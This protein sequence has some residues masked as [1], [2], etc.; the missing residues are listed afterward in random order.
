MIKKEEFE[1]MKIQD[2]VL[3][4]HNLLY[5]FNKPIKTKKTTPTQQE[6]IDHCKSKKSTI[7]PYMFYNYYESKG[8]MIGKNKIKNWKAS[9]A[10]W[11]HNNKNYNNNNENDTKRDLSLLD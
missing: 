8:W 5:N 6:V 3:Y 2:Q 7:D 9:V 1:K 4:L 11:E 10:V